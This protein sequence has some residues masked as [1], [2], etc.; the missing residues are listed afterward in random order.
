MNEFLLFAGLMTI[1]MIIFGVIA[2]YYKYAN[3]TDDDD[4]DVSEDDDNN[5][6]DNNRNIQMNSNVTRENERF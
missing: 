4:D 3:L 2:Y 6:D 5:N 1:D